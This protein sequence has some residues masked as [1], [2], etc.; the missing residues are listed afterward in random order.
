MEVVDFITFPKSPIAYYLSNPCFSIECFTFFTEVYLIIEQCDFFANS[1]GYSRRCSWKVGK[2]KR[3]GIYTKNLHECVIT[4][5][6]QLLF[7][8]ASCDPVIP[9][10]ILMA[11][12]TA[13]AKY[14]WYIVLPFCHL[15]LAFLYMLYAFIS[16]LIQQLFSYMTLYVMS[17]TSQAP[18]REIKALGKEKAACFFY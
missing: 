11:S 16:S 17:T 6:M 2:K 4:H 3:S 1:R 13:E 8:L 18:W 14:N 5:N 15:M 12:H 10:W 9:I 7:L